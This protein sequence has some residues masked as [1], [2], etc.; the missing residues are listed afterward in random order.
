MYQRRILRTLN[1]ELYGA[2]FSRGQI[3]LIG[4][5]EG[6][7]LENLDYFWAHPLQL[8]LQWIHPLQSHYVPRHITNRYINSYILCYC[9]VHRVKKLYSLS[10]CFVFTRHPG[11]TLYQ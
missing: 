11:G 10:R 1:F 9:P 8:P 6:V 3:Y 5:L 4:A 7:G 2:W